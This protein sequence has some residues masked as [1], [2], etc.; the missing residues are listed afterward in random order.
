LVGTGFNFFKVWDALAGGRLLTSVSTHQKTI[1]CSH[2]AHSTDQIDSFLHTVA[3]M[4]LDGK[5]ERLLTGSLDRQVCIHL[6]GMLDAV[7]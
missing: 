2:H 6:S 5:N 3:G 7:I 1:T 4:C